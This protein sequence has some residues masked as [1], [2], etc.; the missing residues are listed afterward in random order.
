MDEAKESPSADSPPGDV[1][2]TEDKTSIPLSDNS[3]CVT[4][5]Q[6]MEKIQADI[7]RLLTKDNMQEKM[8]DSLH[9]QLSFY[10]QDFIN[11]TK[12]PLLLSIILIMD[13]LKVRMDQVE[14]AARQEL[15]Y[16]KQDLADL[17]YREGVEPFKNVP[18]IFDK[19]IQRALG[20]E[21]TSVLEDDQKIARVCREGYLWDD[22][23]LRPQEV[24]V[25]RYSPNTQPVDSPKK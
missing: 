22:R 21:P 18:E 11:Q 5:D 13:R 9:Q 17:L 23:I 12:K 25:K 6:R 15:E 3:P 2:R 7:E 24:I 4:V 14:P 19:K 16:F 1:D 20:G 8:F 10:R